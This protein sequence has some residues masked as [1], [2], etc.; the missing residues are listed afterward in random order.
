MATAAVSVLHVAQRAWEVVR[1]RL[2]LVLSALP[3][4][5][6]STVCLAQTTTAP[7]IDV[8]IY[9]PADGTN[10]LCVQSGSTFWANVFV[11]PGNQSLACS[12]A[13]GSALGGSANLATAVIDVAFSSARLSFNQA[14]NNPSPTTAAVD[15]LIQTQN[16]TG[17]RIGW[18]LAGDWT[19][20]GDTNGSLAD[21]CAMQK[22]DAPGWAFRM[23]IT[24]V[25][26]GMTT[27]HLRR[28]SDV[29]PFALSFADICGSPA[30]KESNGGIDEIGDMVV[31]V[32]S[33]CDDVLF[34]DNFERRDTSAWSNTVG[35]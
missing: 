3:L 34:F 29:S 28:E 4:V 27:L 22:L 33:T 9:N 1:R 2:P 13:C 20:D 32:A 15:G 21:P 31:M 23:Q 30:F 19:P 26:S 35:L 25:G 24:G 12:P 11:R 18:A 6:A 16:V 5:L 14:Q 17:G 8:E 7:G 10:R